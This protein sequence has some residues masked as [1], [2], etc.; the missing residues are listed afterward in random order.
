[1]I[2]ITNIYGRNLRQTKTREITLHCSYV[3]DLNL[4][5][6]NMFTAKDAIIG[7][8]STGRLLRN[9]YLIDMWKIRYKFQ[10]SYFLLALT[11]HVWQMLNQGF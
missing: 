1:M 8:F 9:N 2:Y 3:S 7:K 11:V 4:L 6:K 10:R 5:Y